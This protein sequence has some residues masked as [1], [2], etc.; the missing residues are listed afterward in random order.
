[1]KYSY[2]AGIQ[3]P[4]LFHFGTYMANGAAVAAPRL[5]RDPF[6]YQELS[7]R[8]LV[9]HATCIETEQNVRH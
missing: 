3:V 8:V 5:G 6:P 1:M 9:W 4:S 2:L 7:F